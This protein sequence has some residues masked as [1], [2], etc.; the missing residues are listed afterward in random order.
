MLGHD[1]VSMGRSESPWVPIPHRRWT[2]AA[3]MRPNFLKG[4]TNPT[5]PSE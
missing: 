5:D 3:L 1:T 4:P 2:Q